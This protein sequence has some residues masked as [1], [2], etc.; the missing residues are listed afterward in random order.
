MNGK[1]RAYLDLVRVPNLFTAA[2]DI[3]AGFFYTGGEWKDWRELLALIAASVSLYAGGV[4]LND[5]CDVEQDRR[6]RPGRPIPAGRVSRTAAMN[7]SIT[8]LIAGVVLAACASWRAAIVAGC[9][10]VSIIA[11]DVFL[12][13]TPF[14]PGVMGLCRA[15]N[16][17]LGMS[18][19][20]SVLAVPIL[21]PAG[22]MWLY[23]TSVT[24]F[25]RREAEVSGR[26]RLALGTAGVCSAA[27]MLGV[28]VRVTG[29]VGLTA[30]W[31]AVALLTAWLAGFGVR[32][33]LR[34]VPVRVQ[35]AVKVFVMSL[36]LFDAVI[37][38][39]G[40]NAWTALAVASL[41]VPAVT[42]SRLFRVT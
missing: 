15:L 10:C 9:L 13:A 7:L 16:L 27:V 35:T 21:I 22:L 25:A 18:A 31:I 37:A 4:A 24:F 6:E 30:R 5:V 2:A 33:V 20:P 8:L 32:A 23:I 19:A 3:L 40:S 26:T 36:I 38:W 11:Y 39:T 17:A 42:L 12:K 14:A 1:V 28:L 29:E 41:L 34:P